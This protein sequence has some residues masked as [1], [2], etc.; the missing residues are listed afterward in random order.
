[1]TLAEVETMD[2]DVLSAEEVASV[3]GVK[4][5]SI[6]EQARA[7]NLPLTNIQIGSRVIFPRLAFINVMKGQGQ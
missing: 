7:G 4:A 5:Q 3:L 2:K 6:R 1:M